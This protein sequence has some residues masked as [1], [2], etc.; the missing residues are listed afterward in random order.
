[1]TSSGR[2]GGQYLPAGLYLSSYERKTRRSISNTK[3]KLLENRTEKQ[4]MPFK[5]TGN[6]LFNDVWRYLVIGCFD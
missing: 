5:T 4:I 3:S 1:M 6:W 2:P